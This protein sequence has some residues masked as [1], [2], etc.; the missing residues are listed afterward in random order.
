MST[1]TTAMTATMRGLAE[2]RSSGADWIPRGP[3]FRAA[4]GTDV[5]AGESRRGVTVR[6]VQWRSA[7]T[8]ATGTCDPRRRR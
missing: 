4:I 7:H 3:G 8:Q 5:T 1:I 2:P 6:T